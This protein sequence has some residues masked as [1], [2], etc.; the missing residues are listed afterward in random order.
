MF[1]NVFAVFTLSYATQNLGVAQSSMYIVNIIFEVAAMPFILWAG[2]LA[3]KLGKSKLFCM[4]S[5]ACGLIAIPGMKIIENSGG[6]LFIITAVIIL[7]WS[8][9]YLGIWGVLGSL[10]AQLF[11]TE[12]RYS[13]ISFVYHAPSFLVAGIVPTICTYLLKVGNG[14]VIFIG[15]FV[16][17]V[18]VVSTICGVVLQNRH[19]KAEKLA[20]MNVKITSEVGVTE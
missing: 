11:E 13:G 19:D 9:F 16:A 17:F 10:W 6:N 12:V 14:N 20:K 5:I 4:S 18:A 7:G 1:Y 3:D 2:K 8:I 15:I